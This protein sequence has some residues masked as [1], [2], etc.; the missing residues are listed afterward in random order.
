[1]IQTINLLKCSLVDCPVRLL[2]PQSPR[3][4]TARLRALPISKYYYAS[5]SAR[6]Y[7]CS[8]TI[9]PKPACTS[10][11]RLFFSLASSEA[12]YCLCVS[13]L[14]LHEYCGQFLLLFRA[15]FSPAKGPLVACAA[16]SHYAYQFLTSSI[17]GFP[18]STRC[19][20]H[21]PPLPPPPSS[22][23]QYSTFFY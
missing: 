5:S 11:C 2:L 17:Y 4:S 16:L 10:Y 19:L 23:Q 21:A 18:K 20:P 15:L 8:A 7:W 14:S 22:H 13:A 9:L 12:L 1:M 6:T 3:A